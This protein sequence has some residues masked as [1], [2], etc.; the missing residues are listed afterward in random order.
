[1]KGN[2][3]KRVEILTTSGEPVSGLHLLE[4]VKMT[5]DTNNGT[6]VNT[7][8][9]AAN[10]QFKAIAKKSY[11]GYKDYINTDFTKLEKGKMYDYVMMN[12]P[13]YHG[14][15]KQHLDTAMEF[16]KTGVYCVIPWNGTPQYEH[17]VL[18]KR[19]QFETTEIFG[20][21]IY[22]AKGAKKL[23]RL[24]YK[25][26]KIN[27]AGK[28]STGKS[29][30]NPFIMVAAR[31]EVSKKIYSEV[32]NDLTGAYNLITAPRATLETLIK[33]GLLDK[34]DNAVKEQQQLYGQVAIGGRDLIKIISEI[35]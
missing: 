20:R 14:K 2:I 25:D 22:V 30:G 34:I 15:W 11:K 23:G 3:M 29:F 35:Y 4:G 26:V 28:H 5:A 6:T 17:D 18:N 32:P 21:L 24:I 19:I 7:I 33:R 31:K 10:K 16:A 9:G 12:P 8:C 13:F 27:D 1:M